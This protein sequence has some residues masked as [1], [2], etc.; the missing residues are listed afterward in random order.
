M[1]FVLSIVREIPKTNMWS[2]RHVFLLHVGED[3]NWFS[4]V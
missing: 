3:G 1:C 2:A 4:N